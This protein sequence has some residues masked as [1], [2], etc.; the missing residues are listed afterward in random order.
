[1]RQEYYMSPN[2][3]CEIRM[4]VFFLVRPS[5]PVNPSLLTVVWSRSLASGQG[6]RDPLLERMD[7]TRRK[8]VSSLAP[9]S[10]S[11]PPSDGLPLGF[12]ALQ[13]DTSKNKLRHAWFRAQIGSNSSMGIKASAGFDPWF[14]KDR[15]PGTLITKP[16]LHYVSST[17]TVCFQSTPY[18]NLYIRNLK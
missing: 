5:R 7:R 13:V 4:F 11:Y 17:T 3:S 10:F 18:A 1:M 15:C 16:I 8:G 2:H 6:G 14:S 12:K 9:S